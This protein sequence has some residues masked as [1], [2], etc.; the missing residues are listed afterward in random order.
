M[1]LLVSLHCTRLLGWRQRSGNGGPEV[2]ALVDR[3]RHRQAD[4]RAGLDVD[5]VDRASDLVA[6]WDGLSLDLC[7]AKQPDLDPWPFTAARVK[8]HVDARDLATGAWRTL[9]FDLRP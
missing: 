7:G 3:E 2:D 8:L 1:A 6:R 4:L 5:V 9:S